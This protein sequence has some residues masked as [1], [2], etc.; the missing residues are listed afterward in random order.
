MPSVAAPQYEFNLI[1][2]F[3]YKAIPRDVCNVAQMCETV[4]YVGYF[5]FFLQFLV[6][7]SECGCSRRLRIKLVVNIRDVF[8]EIIVVYHSS[9][10]L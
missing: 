2:F 6:S 5:N 3:L 1:R 7:Y 9:D 10:S 8:L 4:A